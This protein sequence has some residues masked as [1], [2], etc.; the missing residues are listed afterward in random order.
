MNKQKHNKR[1][2]HQVVQMNAT[3]KCQITKQTTTKEQSL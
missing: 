3:K 2:Q 1:R